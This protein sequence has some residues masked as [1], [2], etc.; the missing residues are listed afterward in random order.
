[1]L[2]CVPRDTLIICYILLFSNQL[3]IYSYI[4]R[5]PKNCT[6][7]LR[8]AQA[9]VRCNQKCLDTDGNRFEHLL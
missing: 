8:D 6:H 2:Y 9:V 3:H 7:I 5:V 1:M 4:Q